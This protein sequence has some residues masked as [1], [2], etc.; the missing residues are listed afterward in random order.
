MSEKP[1]C[2]ECHDNSG[3]YP[4]SNGITWHCG[5]CNYEFEEV[6]KENDL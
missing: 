2:P 3:V 1:E 4:L 6:V 5:D